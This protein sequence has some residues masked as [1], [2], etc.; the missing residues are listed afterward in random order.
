V[1]TARAQAPATATAVLDIRAVRQPIYGFGGSQTFN[2]DALLDFRDRKAVYQALFEDLHL[3]IF[4]LRNFNGYDGQQARFDQM[5]REFGSAPRRF[6][7]RAK[8]NG[9]GPVRLMFTSW[10]PPATLKSNKL[11]SGRSDGTEKGLENATLRRDPNGAYAYGA[12]ADWWAD[13]VRQFKRQT[14]V[15]PDYISLQNE[16]DLSVSY[17]GCRFL[18][19]EGKDEKGYEIA[20]YDRALDAVSTRLADRFG[21]T[22][23]KIVG[24]EPFTIQI[25]GDGKNR[26]QNFVDPTTLPGQ[27]SLS[28]L[29]GVS[30]HIYGSGAGE[31]DPAKFNAA[32]NSVRDAYRTPPVAKPLFQTEF[33]EGDTFLALGSLIHDSLTRADA[34]AYF[35]WMLARSTKSPGLAMVYFNPDTGTVEKRER[36]YAMK[37]Y[38]AFVGEGWHRIS[39]DCGNPNLKLSAFLSPD[40]NALVA[41]LINPTGGE[42]KVSLQPT[43]SAFTSA[44]TAAFRSSQGEDGERWRDLGA[45]PAGNV[46]TLTRRSMVTVKFTRKPGITLPTGQVSLVR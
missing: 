15:Y 9:K 34:S 30:F 20:G 24:P 16:L 46:V 43:G 10:S 25:G 13:S 11:V 17:E 2:G 29:F 28:H 7:D 18:P 8:R 6:S 26:V 37:H 40:Q 42:Q 22:A 41:V 19:T 27:V 39:A 44:T 36:F 35:V 32:L 12:F 21:A 4:R 38:S 45:L 31:A 1:H 14:G 23:P 5:I 33:L 3:D